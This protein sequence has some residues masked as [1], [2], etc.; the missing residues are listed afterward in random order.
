MSVTPV[1]VPIDSQQ[2]YERGNRPH[3][4]GELQGPCDP[5]ARR[6]CALLERSETGPA[7][8]MI[9]AHLAQVPRDSRALYL[10]ARAE[11][12]GGNPYAAR[13]DCKRALSAYCDSGLAGFIQDLWTLCDE[14]LGGWRATQPPF[15]EIMD[16]R[17]HN[18]KSASPHTTGLETP[19]ASCQSVA[20][21][22]ARSV[23]PDSWRTCALRTLPIE[24][25]T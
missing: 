21:L 17:R 14:D 9:N 1:S 4:S 16:K 23:L 7:L 10:R 5:L 24:A 19:N 13:E 2:A 25:S 22:K 18:G 15:F 12:I 11:F 3:L 20:K 8:E 6:I